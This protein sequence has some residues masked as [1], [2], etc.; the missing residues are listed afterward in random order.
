LNNNIP[1]KIISHGT[2]RYAVA[3]LHDG[4][5]YAIIPSFGKDAKISILRWRK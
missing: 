1:S 3:E 4:S 2:N 5:R